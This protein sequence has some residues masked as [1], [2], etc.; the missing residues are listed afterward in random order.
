MMFLTL[1]ILIGALLTIAMGDRLDNNF[2]QISDGEASNTAIKI[3]SV[4]A[5]PL[6]AVVVLIVYIV[7]F[8]MLIVKKAD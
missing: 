1:Y 6:L 5:S 4:F 7:K 2:K 3:F 8:G